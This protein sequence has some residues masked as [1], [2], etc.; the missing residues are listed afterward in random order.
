MITNT[1]IALGCV[2]YIVFVL[3]ACMSLVLV[4]SRYYTS[5]TVL[6]VIPSVYKE[7]FISRYISNSSSVQLHNTEIDVAILCTVHVLAVIN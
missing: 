5:V 3:G 6:G 1:I 7:W 4:C 2:L